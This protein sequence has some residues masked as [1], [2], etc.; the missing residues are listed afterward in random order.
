MWI[1]GQTAP[2]SGGIGIEP[3]LSAEKFVA[4]KPVDEVLDGDAMI[5]GWRRSA[6]SD[7][8]R[9]HGSQMTTV[10]LNTTML[11]I[12]AKSSGLSCCSVTLVARIAAV[13]SVRVTA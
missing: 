9:A 4:E 13:N 11:S 7:P 3:Q 8:L 12:T 5:H 10:V 2:F 6:L 1:G